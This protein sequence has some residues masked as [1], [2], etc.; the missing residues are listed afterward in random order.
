[1]RRIIDRLT[2]AGATVVAG[3]PGVVDT[4]TFKGGGAAADEY[5]HN[6]AALGAIDAK[7][8]AE[9][10]LPFADVHDAMLSAMKKAKAALGDAYLVAG[11]DGVHPGADGHLVMAYA[12]LKALGADGKIG[13][14][15]MDWKGKTSA[16]DGHTVVSN[17]QGK[18]ELE[19]T[20]YPFCFTGTEKDPGGTASILPFVPF[21]DDLNRFILVV[22]NL[23]GENAT[24]KWGSASKTFTRERL[25]K[26]V[27][28]AAE[29]Q[30]NPFSKP[31]QNVLGAIG[32]KQT[33]ETL[34][35]KGIITQWRGLEREFAEDAD[36]KKAMEAFRA[37][38]VAHDDDYADQARKAL[39]PVR[40]TI[41][42]LPLP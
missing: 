35:I 30:D 31:F 4:K 42:I 15:T 38:L 34:M 33:Y 3:S 9:K 21:N 19:S 40:H 20:R 28:L 10:G 8:A 41:E 7:I 18:V 36:M 16:T 25:A 39:T 17:A 37:R 26:G 12:F 32:R 29:Y 24:V 13:A 23:P 11:G 2:K 22:T 5:N 6:L 14:I 1:M 27:N